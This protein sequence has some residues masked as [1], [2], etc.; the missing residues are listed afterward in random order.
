MNEEIYK[1]ALLAANECSESPREMLTIYQE[2]FA[3]SLYKR[4]TEHTLGKL[5]EIG[6]TFGDEILEQLK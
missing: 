5:A 2:M 4:F 1:I 3:E 6:I